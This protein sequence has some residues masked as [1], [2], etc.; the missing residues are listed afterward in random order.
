M[1]KTLLLIAVFILM[2][3]FSSPAT[4]ELLAYHEWENL[5]V[6]APG[7]W[8]D[9]RIA[10]IYYDD[11]TSTSVSFSDPFI[12]FGFIDFSIG[13]IGTKYISNSTSSDFPDVATLLT[14]GQD[15]KIG[16]WIKHGVSFA[17]WGKSGT[18]ESSN[19]RE[20]GYP[21]TWYLIDPG[22]TINYLELTILAYDITYYSAID[23][24]SAHY[25]YRVDIYAD[26]AAV[27]E[28]ATMFLLGSGLVGLAGFRRKFR[29]K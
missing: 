6:S 17:S 16:V 28:P 18:M 21:T 12:P 9:M 20:P 29:K 13:T 25:K 22:S 26:A 19:L 11:D 4:A 1:K 8:S 23:S 5:S 2:L 15:D 10:P 24:T 14:N 27:P 3:G 7:N